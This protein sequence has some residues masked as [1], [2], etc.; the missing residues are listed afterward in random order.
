MDSAG[1]LKGFFKMLYICLLQDAQAMELRAYELIGQEYYVS[2]DILRSK[3]F[4]DKCQLGQFEPEASEMRKIFP[5]LRRIYTSNH[6]DLIKKDRR[7]LSPSLSFYEELPLEGS[8][9]V[10]GSGDD[11]IKPIRP[12]TSI[13]TKEKIEER[14]KI[15]ARIRMKMDPSLGV[16][17]K[18]R[19]LQP[20]GE[21]TWH[22]KQD[23]E[24]IEKV[25]DRIGIE[26]AK[27]A[28]RADPMIVTHRSSNRLIT[29]FN[30]HHKDLL[31][32][33]AYYYPQYQTYLTEV[34]LLTIIRYFN[35]CGMVLEKLMAKVAVIEGDKA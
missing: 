32:E 9:Y 25:T 5:N 30:K 27:K 23:S 3:F 21:I 35:K 26:E 4:H 22:H 17:L 16:E 34:G 2:G 31:P 29:C 14:K 19:K 24:F 28:A 13:S 1:A 12:M 6:R 20:V 11:R 7:D 15:S 33:G 18:S 10:F 8:A